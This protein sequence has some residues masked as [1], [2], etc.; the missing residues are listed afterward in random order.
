VVHLA[1]FI[2]VSVIEKKKVKSTRI[3]CVVIGKNLKS[4]QEIA[5]KLIDLEDAEDEIED[6][7]ANASSGVRLADADRRARS[8]CCRNVKALTSL[9]T[10]VRI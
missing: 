8:L 3:T 5:I 10:L 6:I 7:Q 4:G 1:K 2:E 9:V